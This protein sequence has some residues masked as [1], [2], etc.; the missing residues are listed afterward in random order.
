MKFTRFG[1]YQI[2]LSGK[3]YLTFGVMIFAKF[4]NT[5]LFE[6]KQFTKQHTKQHTKQGIK[7]NRKN[8][9]N[10]TQNNTQNK[11]HKTTN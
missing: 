9:Q 8:S 10:K 5:K 7:E 2:H 1:T 6:K 11:T 3:I 4:S